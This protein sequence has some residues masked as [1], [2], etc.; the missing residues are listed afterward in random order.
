MY[1]E[2]HIRELIS[3]GPILIAGYGREGRS[4]HALLQRLGMDASVEVAHNDEE[5]FQRL[6]NAQAHNTPY[7]HI[8]KSPGIPTMKLE[9][10]CNLATITSQ[11][12]IFMQVYG[13]QTIGISGTKGKSTTTTLI[14]HLLHRTL[15][16]RNVIL[17]GNMGIPLFDIIDQLDETAIIVAELSC[18]QLE[19]IHQAPHIG[20]LLNFYQEHLDHYHDYMDYMMAKMQLLLQQQAGD[21]CHYCADCAEL[22]ELVAANRSASTLRPY[23]LK[24]AYNSILH[25]TPLPLQGDHN[26]SNI[27]VAKLVA[28]DFGIDDNSVLSALADFHG[29]PHRLERVGTYCGITFYN[30]SIS[31]IPEATIAAVE[32]LERVDTLILG[33]YDRGI[34]Y[35]PLVEYL[36]DPNRKGYNVHNVVLVGE[37]GRRIGQALGDSQRCILYENRYDSI[38]DWCFQHTRSGQICLLSPAAASYDAF[39][40]FE[41]RGNCFKNLITNHV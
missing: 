18:H 29:L 20:V 17:A 11:T 35:H 24:E 25:A 41:E 27:F 32:T 26:L 36:N 14:H 15:T 5:L 2:Q 19:N 39:K 37:A 31:T 16:D 40:N 4:T 7:R 10:R 30:D 13:Y 8:I 38:V 34:D 33:G 12:D 3:G 6:D 1:K 23:T 22:A 21:I 28:N 9:G